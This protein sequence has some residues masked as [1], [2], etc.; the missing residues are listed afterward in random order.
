MEGN[1]EGDDWGDMDPGDSVWEQ[2][3]TIQEATKLGDLRSRGVLDEEEFKLAKRA[4]L[5]PS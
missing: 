1:E 4:I 3:A 5:N 2:E